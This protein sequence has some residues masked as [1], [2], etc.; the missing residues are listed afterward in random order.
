MQCPNC[1]KD[2]KHDKICPY[3]KVDAVLYS[4]TVRL[5]D[6]LY[7][8]GL[9]KLSYGDIT[10]GIELL[11]RSVSVN[12]NN[13]PARNL[14]G[15]ALFEIGYVGDALKHWV[16]SQS[17]VKDNNLATQYIDDVRRNGR[18][19]EELNDAVVKYNQA[20]TYI[21]HKSD[22]L[23]IIQLKRAIE[24]N[25][26]F[27]DALNLL[28]LCHLIQN[29]REKAAAAAERVL[30]IDIQNTVALN[31]LSIINPNRAKPEPRHTSG[32]K[33]IRGGR[34][35]KSS[36][37]MYKP[38]AM[39]ERKPRAFRF[40]II[41]A[42]VI[43]AACAFAAMYVLLV[44]ALDRQHASQLQVYQ[45][46][47]T[48]AENARQEDAEAHAAAI[49]EMQDNIDSMQADVAA[50]EAQFDLQERIILFNHAENL[51]RDGQLYET[52]NRLDEI[53][54]DGFPPDLVARYDDMRAIAYP[55]LAIQFRDQGV[56]AFNANDFYLA[57]PTLERALRFM[58][59]ED[60][61]PRNVAFLWSLANLYYQDETRHA[62]A[63]E[64]LEEMAARFPHNTPNQRNNLL[65]RLTDLD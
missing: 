58:E 53:D 16:V 40:D 32:R 20:L 26:S 54:T 63:R 34:A 25:P 50:V 42:L 51:F 55:Q 48:A 31:Y 56:A 17:L 9:A 10:Q 3:C 44:P 45:G 21:N 24:L 11:N 6:K 12:K 33:E 23:A 35:S 49:A 39:Q 64:L 27:I 43:G 37:P 19:L 38:V 60:P 22:D 62:E 52:I 36:I 5:S 28:C 4:G 13:V 29:D 65:N 7:N 2:Y 41:L 18:S 61:S 47:V 15:L 59:P 8:K 30:A 57:L 14:L 46:R 1:Q